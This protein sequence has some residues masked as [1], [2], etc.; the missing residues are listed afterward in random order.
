MVRAETWLHFGSGAAA[1]ARASA[2]VTSTPRQ[3]RS[4]A[5]VRPTGPAPTISTLQSVTSGIASRASINAAWTE[6]HGRRVRSFQLGARSLDDGGPPIDFGLY[7]RRKAVRCRVRQRLQRQQL[8]LV[9]GGGIIEELA[10]LGCQSI[11]DRPWQ[12]GGADHALPGDQLEPFDAA[13]GQCRNLRRRIDTRG[14][15]DAER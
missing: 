5:S 10:D 4:I 11:D 9:A 2:T 6:L 1:G 8:E 7:V 12:G 13:L 15:G 14:R 3:A